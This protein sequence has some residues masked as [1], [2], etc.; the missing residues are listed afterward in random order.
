VQKQQR[1][2]HP[3]DNGRFKTVA[4]SNSLGRKKHLHNQKTPQAR[5]PSSEENEGLGE[6]EVR[7]K[8]RGLGG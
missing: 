8:E 1:R 3:I 5:I 7:E 2:S 6:R 4:T